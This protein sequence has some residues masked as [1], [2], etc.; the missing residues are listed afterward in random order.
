MRQSLKPIWSIAYLLLLT[1]LVS[2][3]AVRPATQL[4]N[5]QFPA[6]TAK[7]IEVVIQEEIARQNLPGLSFAESNL[8]CFLSKI[9]CESFYVAWPGIQSDGFVSAVPS[10]VRRWLRSADRLVSTLGLCPWFGLCPS[11]RACFEALNWLVERWDV[12]ASQ[13]N[14]ST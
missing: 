1:A 13:L 12:V 2:A 3:Q 9:L 5:G 8:A 11:Q 14:G 6:D 10:D 4:Q 7:Q